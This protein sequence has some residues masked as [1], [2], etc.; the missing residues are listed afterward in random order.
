MSE[1]DYVVSFKTLERLGHGDALAG[2]RLLR[3]LIDV[4]AVREPIVGPVAKPPNVRFATEGDEAAIM[5]LLRQDH[6]ENAAMVADFNAEHVT[7]FIQAAT[8]Q[9]IA[10][11]GVIDDP[12]G[13]VAMVYMAPESWWF[14][15]EWY[16]AE[17]LLYVHRD[18]RRTRHAAHLLDFARWFVD[19]MSARLG[20]RVFL[21]SSVVGTR[22][23]DKKVALF[24][25]TMVRAGGVFV[26]P[27]P[28]A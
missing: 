28:G 27:D 25:R 26:Y 9:R 19:D 22:D 21:I 10:T 15:P 14:A 11:I 18:H 17:R 1:D 16:I 24:G 23:V 8:R 13:P 12:E 2:R 3:T 5:E 20:Y 4:E 6:A 7:P